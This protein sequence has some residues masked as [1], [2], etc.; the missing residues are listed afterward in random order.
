VTLH[1]N[2]N[3]TISEETR[4]ANHS[5]QTISA[6]KSKDGTIATESDYKIMIEL[7]CRHSNTCIIQMIF[8]QNFQCVFVLYP[9]CVMAFQFY[10]VLHISIYFY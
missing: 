8:L 6:P 9:L 4:Q 10:K 5:P 2:I 7:L 1:K 3:L